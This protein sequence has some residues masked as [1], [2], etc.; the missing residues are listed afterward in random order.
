MNELSIMKS[1]I[2]IINMIHMIS[3]L[4]RSCVVQYLKAG[5]HCF[6]FHSSLSEWNHLNVSADHP[7][8]M[9][10][11]LFETKFLAEDV[12]PARSG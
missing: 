1:L 5:S 11:W 2:I 6:L 7:V 10:N 8:R 3:I 12:G 9:C 4:L